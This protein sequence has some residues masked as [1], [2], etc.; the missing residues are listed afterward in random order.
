MFDV[1]LRR[2]LRDSSLMLVATAASAVLGLAQVMLVTRLL[3][4]E[5][6]GKLALIMAISQSVRQF[7]GVRIWEWAMKEFA[8]AHTS[9]DPMYAAA[10]V[11]RG[12]VSSLIVN[13]LSF[14]I[15][16]VGAPFAA[17]RFVHD[18]AMATLVV[19]YGVVLLVSW[20]YD[21]AF[22]VL[23][24]VGHF[25]FLAMQQIGMSLLRIIVTGG[26]VVLW[27]RLEV[28]IC[29]YI[30]VEIIA[31]VWLSWVAARAFTSELGV[32]FWSLRRATAPRD[33][34]MARLVI[35]GSVMDTLKLA[36]TR[37]DILVLGWFRA[38]VA[39]ANY[40]AAWNFLDIA[41][42]VTQP[43]TMVAFADLAKLGSTGEGKEIV[44]IVGKLSLL[45]F[46]VT[47][48]ACAAL[49]LA[50]PLLCHLI[51]GAGYPDAPGLLQILAFSLMWLT[52]L[53]MLPSFV[54]IGKPTWGLE[55][56]G[57]MTAIKVILL[58][59]LTPTLGAK[60]VAIAN[61]AYSLSVPL[62][63][64]LYFWRLRRWVLSPGFKARKIEAPIVA[65]VPA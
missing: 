11:R 13:L 25:R 54:S 57:I 24:V 21:T 46:A 65:E 3:G 40:Q 7:M 38:P 56:V 15:V 48:P 20:T 23:R 47:L 55:V 1:R 44:R 5:W 53:W 39:V 32:S 43:I 30:V 9:K 63:L 52:G 16:V 34:H 27:P 14:A 17:G 10:V 49:Y 6:Y 60:G 35:I 18:P 2:I 28:T 50:A 51:Y 62:M 59:V 33:V 12:L 4:A 37:L 45:A 22:A 26:S 41:A 64:P 61:L 31:S 8:H 42:R 36:A 58:V 29:S 19:G